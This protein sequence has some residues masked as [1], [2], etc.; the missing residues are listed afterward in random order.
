MKKI[1]YPALLLL[2]YLTI[3]FPFTSYMKNK[4]YV[5][6]LG[7]LP[8]GEVIKYLAAD[9]KEF[10]AATLVLKVLMYYGGLV[11]KSFNKLELPID[12]P[13]MSR[14]L[15][16]AVKLDPY[17]MDAYYFAQANFVW[18]AKQ[19]K[20]VNE[21]LEYGMRYRTWDY[22]LPFYAGFNS[23]YFLKDFAKAAQYYRKAG[24]LSGSDL[25]ISLAGRYL[26]ESGRSDLA[27]AY[28]TTMEKGAQ[29]MTIKKAFQI[30]LK[31][32]KEGQRIEFARDRY[33]QETGHLPV[34][35]D[36]LLQKGYLLE[37]PLDPYGGKFYLEPDGSVRST[38][39][40]AFGA[41]EGK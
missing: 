5:E 20:I 35:V 37:K 40:F 10:I 2:L 28:L 22:S 38:S 36:E 4:P 8:K 33:M 34:S 41:A 14:T 39:K 25:F 32:L 30:R 27:I 23:A 12:Y 31:A 29:S 18:D 1:V 17:N 13:A 26:Y 19:F 16:A 3:L 21:L 6:K 11:D 9:Q 15:H 24:E 7:Y